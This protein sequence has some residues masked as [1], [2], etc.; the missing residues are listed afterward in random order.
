MPQPLYKPDLDRIPLTV[1]TDPIF[2]SND[3][4]RVGKTMRYVG[5]INTDTTWLIQQI[6]STRLE[7]YGWVKSSV[8]C[9]VKSQDIVELRCEQTGEVK[10]L[11]ANYLEYSAIWRL[12]Q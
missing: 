3:A 4:I 11:I 1:F 7:K 8:P 9:A 5:R 2:F 10:R 12:D 6:W